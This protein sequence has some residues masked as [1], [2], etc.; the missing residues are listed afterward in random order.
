MVSVPSSRSAL[1]PICPSN[2]CIVRTSFRRGTLESTSGSGVSSAAQ[3]IGSA[4]FLAPETRISPSSRVPPSINSLSTS[5]LSLPLRPLRGGQRGHR[6]RMDFLAHAR[7]QRTVYELVAAHLGECFEST[8]HDE[9]LKVLPVPA[10][11]DPLAGEAGLEPRLDGVR[12]GRV[13][14]KVGCADV[15]P[16]RRD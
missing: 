13:E 16:P 15:E 11:P 10:D 7:A 6:Q 3:R 8:A 14:V 5:V 4:A 9:R 12:G 1:T 2:V